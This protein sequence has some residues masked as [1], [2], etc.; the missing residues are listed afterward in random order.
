MR[1]PVAATCVVAALTAATPSAHALEM[2]CTPQDLCSTVPRDGYGNP[3]YNHTDPAKPWVIGKTDV[4]S[5]PQGNYPVGNG[6]FGAPMVYLIEGATLSIEDLP[7]GTE[8]A[9]GAW[10]I[11]CDQ[12]QFRVKRSLFRSA[13][14]FPFQYPIIAE[15][16]SA[17]FFDEAQIATV[18]KSLAQAGAPG[19]LL[20]VMGGGST[21]AAN[22]VV[23]NSVTFERAGEAWEL[24]VVHQAT[25]TVRKADVFGEFYI[26][27][28]ATFT[29]EDSQYFDVF[30]EACPS[31]PLA[32]PA[33]PGLCTIGAGPTQCVTAG[34]PPLDF[35]L[36]PP[37]TTF[38]LS[39][40]N[41]KVFSWAASTYPYSKLTVGAAPDDANFCVGL[42]V[43]GDQHLKLNPG[44]PPVKDGLNDRDLTFN[45]TH[46][47]GW[48]VWPAGTATVALLA[49][50]EV[51]DFAAADQVTG[52]ARGVT[53]ADGMLVAQAQGS[54]HLEDCTVNERFQ[55]VE[56]K[57]SAARTTFNDGFSV[58]GDTWLADCTRPAANLEDLRPE[59][60]IYEVK[61]TGPAEGATLAGPAFTVAGTVTAKDG[62]GATIDPFPPAVIEVVNSTTGTPVQSHDI[63]APAAAPAQW[64]FDMGQAPAG[65]YEARLY[66]TAADGRDAVSRRTIHYAPPV[67]DAGADAAGD[68]GVVEDAGAKPDAG[69]KP[70][71]GRPDAGSDAGQPAAAPGGGEGGCSCAMIR[72]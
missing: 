21:L 25:A 14:Q 34:H 20:Q 49:G 44:N 30:F 54:L 3:D 48:H 10:F 61:L 68:A 66:F 62:A 26:A 46:V 32:I 31:V 39:L 57:V 5:L 37:D 52:T 65:T 55:N 33:L 22:P 17:V 70:D 43:T 9:I 11:I 67:P 27:G 19:A 45:G 38:T 42:S 69:P 1:S 2:F 50:S 6:P 28:D 29:V 24:A 72:M 60:K 12:A 59:A 53:F 16:N 15:G 23:K 58:A 4:I 18:E 51:G 7:A 13:A 36:G 71:A 8:V 63:S 56:A 47:F 35:S 40:K 41:D 64:N